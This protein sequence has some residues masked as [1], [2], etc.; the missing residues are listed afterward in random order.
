MP[1][2]PWRVSSGKQR[3]A[4]GAMI[5]SEPQCLSEYQTDP[6]LAL[7]SSWPPNG[8]TAWWRC[9]AWC[10]TCGNYRQRKREQD[11]GKRENLS[12]IRLKDFFFLW[13]QTTAMC[14]CIPSN[15]G[16]HKKH[17]WIVRNTNLVLVILV[18]QLTDQFHLCWQPHICT[19][20]KSY[21]IVLKYLKK[22]P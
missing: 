11:E 20:G 21:C 22:L 19:C 14:T 9:T 4:N 1:P 8:F 10:T 7:S 18:S 17:W 2:N 16:L 15:T 6:K 5:L 12:S 13:V 3:P